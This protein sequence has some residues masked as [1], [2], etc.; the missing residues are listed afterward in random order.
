[1]LTTPIE[2][3]NVRAVKALCDPSQS[4]HGCVRDPGRAPAPTRFWGCGRCV[5]EA[6]GPPLAQ[7]WSEIVMQARFSDAVPEVLLTLW[8]Q[9]PGGET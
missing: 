3:E 4:V 7:P 9:E 6:N 2:L 1:M 5:T 8:R